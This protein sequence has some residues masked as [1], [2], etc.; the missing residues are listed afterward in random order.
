MLNYDEA[1]KNLE[2][3]S[4]KVLN[5]DITKHSVKK[6]HEKFDDREIKEL[7]KGGFLVDPSP[8][9]KK[10]VGMS[11]P[12]IAKLSL[13]GKQQNLEIRTTTLSRGET[14]NRLITCVTTSLKMLVKQRL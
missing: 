7:K 14:F 5:Q 9:S 10:C 1:Q 11:S 6:T 4:R 3:F 8:I 12:S 13:S 2:K